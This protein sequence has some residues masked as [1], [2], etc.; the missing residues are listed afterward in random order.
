VDKINKVDCSILRANDEFVHCETYVGGEFVIIEL[1]RNLFPEQIWY[2][3]PCTLEMDGDTPVIKPRE[4]VMT[5]QRQKI[6]DEIENI[7]EEL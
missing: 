3:M 4:L 6:I 7:I 2:G 5:E 1:S